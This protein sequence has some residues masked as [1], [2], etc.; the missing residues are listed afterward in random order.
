MRDS[1]A[2]DIQDEGQLKSALAVGISFLDKPQVELNDIA[3]DLN[4]NYRVDYWTQVEKDLKI[5]QLGITQKLPIQGP[6][7]ATNYAKI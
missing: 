7:S 5:Q 4:T 6:N 3:N 2:R 1:G